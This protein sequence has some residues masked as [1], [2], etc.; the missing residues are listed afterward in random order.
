[1]L[2]L[3][4]TSTLSD[5]LLNKLTSLWSPC[6]RDG[7]GSPERQGLIELSEPLS[8]WVMGAV[9]YHEGGTCVSQY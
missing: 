3:K 2:I 9:W 1:M 8:P 5:S 7:A 6:A 4:K